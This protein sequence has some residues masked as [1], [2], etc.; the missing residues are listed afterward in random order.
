MKSQEVLQNGPGDTDYLCKLVQMIE[1]VI[2]ESDGM[3]SCMGFLQS[4]VSLYAQFWKNSLGQRYGPPP[5]P[6]C[7]KVYLPKEDE[8]AN[9][10]EED[11]EFPTFNKL[12]EELV[13]IQ[14]L[15]SKTP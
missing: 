8:D 2:M 3:E 9:I 13:M 12:V 11:T 7:M 6:E 1:E 14:K 5:M 15:L 4:Q 10:E